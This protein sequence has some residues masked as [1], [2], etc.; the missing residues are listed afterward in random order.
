VNPGFPGQR[1]MPEVLPKVG[2]AMKLAHTSPIELEL[3]G[4]VDQENAPIIVRAGA[5]ILVAGASIFRKGDVKS[6]FHEMRAVVDRT[7]QEVSA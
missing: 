6:A 4:G 1:F 2:Q 7:L 5:T 3:D